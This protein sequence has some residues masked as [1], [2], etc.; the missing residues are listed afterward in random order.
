MTSRLKH[1]L[2]LENINL[3]SAYLN[4]SFVQIGTPL[5]D[6]ASTKRDKL[7]YVPEWQQ[8]VSYLALLESKLKRRS[9]TRKEDVASMVLS[10]VVSPQDTSTRSVRRKVS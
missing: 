6:L 3:K 4:E 7:E 8:E 5:P 10:R 9:G 2:E 1:K